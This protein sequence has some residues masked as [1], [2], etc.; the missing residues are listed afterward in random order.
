MTTKKLLTETMKIEDEKMIAEVPPKSP[1]WIAA[2]D[3]A[4]VA[5]LHNILDSKNKN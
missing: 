1:E 5:I 2:K 4:L 3:N